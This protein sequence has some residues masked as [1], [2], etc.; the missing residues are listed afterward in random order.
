MPL[1]GPVYLFSRFTAALLVLAG[2]AANAPHAAAYEGV[3]T[4]DTIEVRSGA[5]RAYYP[6]GTLQRGDRV[7]V[8]TELFGWFQIRCPEGVFSYVEQKN[9][10]AKGDGSRG[11]INTDRTSVYAAHADTGKSPAESYR[12]LLD[13]ERGD[14]VQIVGT[15]DNYYKIIPPQTAFV[16][17]PPKSLEAAQAVAVDAPAAPQTPT[18]PADTPRVTPPATPV[19]DPIVPP[20]VDPIVAPVTAPAPTQPD[21]DAPRLAP[22]IT[23]DLLPVEPTSPTLPATT[24]V[25]IA[26]DEPIAPIEPVFATPTPPQTAP[27][28]PTALTEPTASIDPVDVPAPEPVAPPTPAPRR[29]ATMY[30][31]PGEPVVRPAL[32]VAPPAPEPVNGDLLTDPDAVV[33]K[34]DVPVSSP[35]AH[36]QVVAVEAAMLPYFTLPVD[37]QPLAHMARGYAGLSQLN[38]LT[39]GDQQ[40]VQSRLDEL[41]RN[42]EMAVALRAKPDAAEPDQ[43]ALDTPAPVAS[44]PAPAPAPVAIAPPTPA[45]AP[46]PAAS[47]PVGVPSG[48][49]IDATQTTTPPVPSPA[50][51]GFDAVGVLTVSTVHTG[52]NQPELLRLLDPSGQRTIAYLEPNRGI[53]TALMLGQL[54]GITG[55]SS[56]DPSLKLRLIKPDQIVVLGAVR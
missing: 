41:E 31:P 45:P 44:E 13:L 43:V 47:V 46:T 42:R 15:V 34:P 11:E 9:V 23:P 49:L 53:D 29:V 25:E 10:N 52:E 8:E 50:G 32:P 4:A 20:V 22:V 48:L 18:P 1:R 3:I 6:V 28:A 7:Q 16:F 38:G 40:L 35:A 14:V 5:G 55:S 19:V 2:I 33:A 36:P 56:Y 39:D 37:E 12:K 17:L 26:I 21:P 54:V 51:S 27:V 30:P 24:D